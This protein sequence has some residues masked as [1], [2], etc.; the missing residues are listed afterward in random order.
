MAVKEQKEIQTKVGDIFVNTFGY[1]MT[2]QQFFQV[3]ELKG[4]KAILQEVEIERKP[5]GFLQYDVRPIKNKFIERNKPITKIIQTN[6]YTDK[7]YLSM[8]KG[9]GYAYKV[10][11]GEWYSE[12]HAD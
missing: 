7:E 2:L 8:G 10:K 11:E 3:I 5:T 1:N 12:N 9:Y 6:G 4:R